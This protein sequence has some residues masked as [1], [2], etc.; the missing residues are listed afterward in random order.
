[1]ER[2][3]A[4]EHHAGIAVTRMIFAGIGTAFALGITG[5][6]RVDDRMEDRGDGRMTGTVPVMLTAGNRSMRS[7]HAFN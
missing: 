4:C 1:M 2:G 5:K 6:S 3:D 7:L